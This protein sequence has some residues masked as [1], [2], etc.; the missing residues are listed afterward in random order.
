MQTS[1]YRFIS[2][3]K[4][5]LKADHSDTLDKVYAIDESSYE[6][7]NSRCFETMVGFVQRKDPASGSF[8]GQTEYGCFIGEKVEGERLTETSE[9]I[10]EDEED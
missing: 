10:M 7:F 5:T 8:L 3:F 1:T 2:N 9:Q 4:H 6:A